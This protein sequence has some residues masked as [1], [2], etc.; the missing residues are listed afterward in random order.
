MYCDCI[1]SCSLG[2]YKVIFKIALDDAQWLLKE[3]LSLPVKKTVLRKKRKQKG[4][5]AQA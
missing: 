4:V 5:F 2:F 1:S 3:S